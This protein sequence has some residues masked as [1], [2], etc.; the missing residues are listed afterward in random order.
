MSSMCVSDASITL[1]IKENLIGEVWLITRK[2]NPKT[3][4]IQNNK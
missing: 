4:I 1:G 3:R 2:T